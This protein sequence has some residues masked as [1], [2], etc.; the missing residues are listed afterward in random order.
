[1]IALCEEESEVATLEDGGYFLYKVR[2]RVTVVFV[3][4]LWDRL[5]DF[6][7]CDIVVFG[8]LGLC[9]LTLEDGCR[10]FGKLCSVR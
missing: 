10:G 1:M 5:I 7:L 2:N 6:P 8:F 9:Q 4:Y 3:V